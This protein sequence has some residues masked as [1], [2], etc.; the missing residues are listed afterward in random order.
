VPATPIRTLR[1]DYLAALL[2]GDAVRARYLV[3]QAVEEGADVRKLYLEVFE[4]ALNEVGDLW[5][6]GEIN[7]ATEHYATAVTQGVLGSLAPRM[8][9]APTSGRLA[10]VG[11]VPGEQHALG[12]QM[13]ADFLESEAWEVLSLGASVPAPDLA[14]LVDSERPDAVCLSAATAQTINGIA[15]ALGRLGVL[16]PRPLLVVGGHI[17]QV[18]PDGALQRL[19]ADATAANPR[20]LIGLLDERL[21]AIPADS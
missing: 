3:E 16:D 10:V 18:V 8:R 4:P 21:P 17:T 11:C 14:A 13:I 6:A 9:V 2:A 15:E 19:G 5:A 1:E 7:A 20:E 12:A